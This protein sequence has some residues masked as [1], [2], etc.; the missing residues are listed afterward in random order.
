V[1][2]QSA[3]TIAASD[4]VRVVLIQPGTDIAYGGDTD[5]PDT[6]TTI[7]LDTTTPDTGTGTEGP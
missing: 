6:D 1:S 7:A 3:A 2:E 5:T 4:D